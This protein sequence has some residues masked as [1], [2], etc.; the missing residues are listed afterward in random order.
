MRAPV[1]EV[2]QPSAAAD[3]EDT[4]TF[5]R[6]DLVP[7]KREEVHAEC[8]NV[9][10]QFANR[11]HSIRME[12]DVVFLCNFTNLFD[13]LDCAVFVVDVHDGD[14]HSGVADCIAELC[15]INASISIYREIRNLET[16]LL[17]I[18]AG[19][20]NGVMLH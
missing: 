8:L 10:R 16:A 18:V 19:M 6:V 13:R 3:V 2:C 7:R 11:L 5:G 1:D 12:R 14:Q 15:N 4:D 20:Q 17:E 9:H